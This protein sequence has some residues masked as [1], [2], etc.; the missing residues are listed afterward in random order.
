MEGSHVLVSMR[1]ENQINCSYAIVEKAFNNESYKVIIIVKDTEVAIFDY[2][3][4][5]D[6]RKFSF[7][8]LLLKH[9]MASYE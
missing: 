7:H 6:T 3:L 5:T 1:D 8:Y 2:S 9:H 4:F